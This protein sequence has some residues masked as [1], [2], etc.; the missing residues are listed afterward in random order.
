MSSVPLCALCEVLFSPCA[1]CEVLDFPVPL[2]EVLLSPEERSE[3]PKHTQNQKQGRRE[4]DEGRDDQRRDVAFFH[5]GFDLG[6]ETFLG[7]FFVDKTRKAVLVKKEHGYRQWWQAA[8]WPG[9][10]SFSSGVTSRQ[11]SVT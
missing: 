8:K 5:L 10:V 7:L 3:Q 1:L 9:S 11:M 2:C 4:D 6:D